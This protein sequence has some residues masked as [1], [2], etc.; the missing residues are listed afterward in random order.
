MKRL[1]CFL[2]LSAVLLASVQTA[3]FADSFT[4]RN[5]ILFGDSCETVKSKETIPFSDSD[6]IVE[7]EGIRHIATLSGTVAGIDGCEV[8]FFFTPDDKLFEMKYSYMFVDSKSEIEN[9]YETIYD[10]LVRKY[11]K[12]LSNSGGKISLITTHAIDGAA[13][14]IG[15]YNLLEMDADYMDYNEWIVETDGSNSVKIEMISFYTGDYDDRA[16]HL[17]VGYRLF[18]PDDMDQAIAEQQE[19]RAVVDDDL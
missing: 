8:M 7:D 19:K 11:G 12:P 10:G 15:L 5:G 17:N 18:S 16:Y 9:D 14:L 13:V 2:L 1:I 3:A 6:D 4:L